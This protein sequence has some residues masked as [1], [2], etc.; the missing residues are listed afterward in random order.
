MCPLVDRRWLHL[1]V[2][3]DL[4]NGEEAF[5]RLLLLSLPA[6]KKAAALFQ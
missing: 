4:V 1:Q 5:H 3:R 2:S 6:S